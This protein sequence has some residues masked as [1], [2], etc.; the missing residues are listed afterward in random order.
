MA[1]RKNIGELDNIKVYT[2]D[3]LLNEIRTNGYKG[4]GQSHG[5]DGDNIGGDKIIY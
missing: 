2:K 5:G 4:G 1:G 3:S